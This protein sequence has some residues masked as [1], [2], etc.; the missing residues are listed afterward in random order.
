MNCN[1]KRRITAIVTSAPLLACTLPALA[2]DAAGPSATA[3]I[4][5]SDIIVTARKRQESILQVPVVVTA[6]SGETLQNLQVTQVSDLP[7]L[8]PGLVLGGNLLS[9][10]PQVTIRG[11]GTSSSDPGVDQSVSLNIDGLS[12]GQGLAFGSGMFDVAQVEVLKGPQ[13]LFYGKSSPGGVISL[14]TADPTDK[15]E[16]IARASYDFEGREGRG[17]LIVSGP[18]TETLKL[19][20][21]GTYSEGGGY[22]YNVAVPASG[23]GALAPRRREPQPRNLVL[24][25]TALWNPL[26]GL[27]ARLKVNHAYDSSIHGELFQLSSCPSGSDQAFGF[28]SGLPGSPIPPAPNFLTPLDPLPFTVGNDCKLN[29]DLNTVYMDPAAFPGITNGGVPYLTNKQDFGTLELNYDLGSGLS[30]NSTTA[31]YNLR[32]SSLVN[33]AQSGPAGVALAVSNDFRRRE[34]T[35]ELRLNSDFSGPLNFTLGGFYQDGQIYDR[36]IFYRNRTYG[37]LSP[38]VIG[39]EILNDDRSTTV[40]IKTYS[41]FGQ[42]RYQVLDTLELA[43]GVR[44]NDETRSQR[45]YDFLNDVDLTP[46][47]PRTRINAKNFSPEITMNYTPTSDL[48]IFGS[49]KKGYKSGSFKMGVPPVAGE[50]NAFGDERVQGYELGMKA[51]LL[52]RRMLANIAFYDYRYRG[53]QVGGIEPSTSGV[54]VIRTVNAGKARTYGVDFDISYRPPVVEGLSVNG[55]LNW[56]RARYLELGNV[57]CYTGQ[58]IAQGCTEFFVPSASQ[59]TSLPGSVQ[60]GGQSGFYT[61][62]D[63]SGAPLIRAPKWAANFGF[64]YEVPVGSGLRL[65]ATNNNQYSSRYTT[66]LATERPNDDQFQDKYIKVDAS[67]ALMDKDDRWEVALI[68]RNITK[69]YTTA[70]CTPANFAGGNVIGNP[71]TGGTTTGP[72]GAAAVGCYTDPGRAVYLRLTLRPFN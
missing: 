53:L 13:A 4:D 37:F 46:T 25:G 18:V 43:A 41:L 11:V 28:G 68:G 49:Y 51:R 7:R 60:V 5:S 12:L 32:S 20:L 19:R 70:N 54:P 22:F 23:T 67:L 33:S 69:Q 57:P 55:S 27:T 15:N 50:D 9:I 47:L 64:S 39:A 1:R 48:T 63:L 6:V 8:V 35:Q 2:Q 62:Q 29:R 31:Y 61:G 71:I 17:E 42:A 21:A 26:D 36:V 40:D 3:S 65:M 72:S 24:R 14:R 10:G 30:L 45:V 52:D 38:A 66:F 16:L 34:F 59:A 58:T 56:N 44:W